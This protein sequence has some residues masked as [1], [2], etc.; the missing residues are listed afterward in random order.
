ML[1]RIFII[2]LIATTASAQT[3]ADLEKRLD[4]MKQQ[5]EILT[6]EIEA[7][8]MGEQKPAAQAD[9][10]QYGLGA[11]ASKVYRAEPG[12]SFGGYGEFGYFNPEHGTPSADFVRGV[13]Y[14]GYKFNDRVLFNSELEVEHG[15]T[16]IGGSASLE[17]AYLDYLIKP[18]ANVRAGLVLLPM[19]I[20]NERHE[21]TAY[22]GARRPEVEDRILPT[23][24][25]ELGAGVFGD[26]GSITYRGYLVTGLDS[27]RFSAED[28]IHEGKQS[29]SEALAHD[30]AVT[31]RVDWHPFEGALLGAS[32]YSGGS[33]QGRGYKGNVTL[34]DVH[35]DA[36]F[37]GVS[38]RGVFARGHI[39]DAAAISQQNGQTIGSSTGGWYVEGGYDLP[40]R[41][42]VTPYVR[43]ERLDTQRR[44]PLGFERDPENDRRI[45]TFG[46]ALK[47]I[48]QT[49]I[50]ADYQ[51]IHTRA[52]SNDNQLNLALGYIF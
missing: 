8:K 37:R 43:Y 22:L 18:Q 26:A 40:T 42:A 19:G 13:L 33:G 12:V 15:T 41:L 21:P 27:T 47:P 5:I 51:I 38:L 44:V 1:K 17:F 24:W 6:K 35:A 45:T 11:A 4:E 36:K 32:V 30:L 28:S 3:S 9:V 20:I 52:G 31:G 10:S 16:E 46:F 50:K 48:S 23:T 39:G 14:T 25:S 2:L 7:L 29:G 34:G 49:V